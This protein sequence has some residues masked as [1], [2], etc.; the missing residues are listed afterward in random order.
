M[1][2]VQ[3]KCCSQRK[4]CLTMDGYKSLT[5][6]LGVESKSYLSAQH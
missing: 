4:L 5:A 2:I 1:F 6:A 3:D